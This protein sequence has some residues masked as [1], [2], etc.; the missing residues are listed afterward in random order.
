VVEAVNIWLNRKKTARLCHLT[1]GYGFCDIH[2]PALYHVSSMQWFG[3]I[4]YVQSWFGGD[5]DKNL[6]WFDE[7]LLILDGRHYCRNGGFF[8]IREK[9]LGVFFYLKEAKDD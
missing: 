9:R 7:N 8:S 3:D 5:S 1:Y 4:L 2:L 6:I